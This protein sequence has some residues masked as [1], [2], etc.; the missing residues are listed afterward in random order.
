MVPIIREFYANANR[1]RAIEHRVRSTSW[2]CGKDIRFDGAHLNDML[3][4]PNH[5]PCAYW[6]NINHPVSVDE[7]NAVIAI[8]DSIWE[9]SKGKP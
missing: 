7:V 6:A 3:S 2:V 4:L 9:F 8:P 1:D 5:D